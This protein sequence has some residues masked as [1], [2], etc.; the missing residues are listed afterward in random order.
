MPVVPGLGSFRGARK[1]CFEP[2][3]AAFVGNLAPE[4]VGVGPGRI[5]FAK[6]RLTALTRKVRAFLCFSG[7]QHAGRPAI[8]SHARELSLAIHSPHAGVANGVPSQG[9]T[10]TTIL[11]GNAPNTTLVLPL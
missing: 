9:K 4:N 3:H 11:G 7:P 10:P 8:I 1:C 5:L 6:W 2:N